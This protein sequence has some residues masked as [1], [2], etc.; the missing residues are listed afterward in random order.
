MH[1]GNLSPQNHALQ[2]SG[3]NAEQGSGGLTV[4]QWL[5]PWPP[6]NGE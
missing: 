2:R 3:M 4:E 5:Y 6:Q 1:P